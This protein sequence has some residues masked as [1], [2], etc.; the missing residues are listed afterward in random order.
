M[1][2]CFPTIILA[3]IACTWIAA[4][5][6][7]PKADDLQGSWELQRLEANGRKIDKKP[8]SMI[9]TFKED[10][11]VM[12]ITP[13]AGSPAMEHKYKISLSP[14]KDP[15]EIEMEGE[16]KGGRKGKAAGIYEIKDDILRLGLSTEK[17]EER[18]TKFESKEGTQLLTFK[19]IE[20]A[21]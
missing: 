1:N 3:V 16:F 12:K 14:D 20:I 13:V 9:F 4:D 15:A 18:P 6:Q 2:H 5:N 10:E 21:E 11:L 7:K 17:L 8:A 19:R